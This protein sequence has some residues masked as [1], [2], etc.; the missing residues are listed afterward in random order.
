MGRSNIAALDLTTGLPTSWN[1]NADDTVN[2]IAVNGTT[3][4]AGGGF[5]SI[6]GPRPSTHIAALDATTGNTLAWFPPVSALYEFT[7]YN[8]IYVIALAISGT[9]VYAGGYFSTVGQGIG[10]P[11][12]AQFD[13]SYPVA[14]NLPVPPSSRANNVGLQI[15]GLNLHSGA[16][17]KFAYTLLKSGRVTL[18]LYNYIG[19]LQFELVNRHE[20]A[21]CHTQ[22]LNKGRL[23]AG[24]YLV[25][26]K[27]GDYHQ[28]KMI[29]LMR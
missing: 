18:R 19:Q 24:A 29:F 22:S 26:F 11:F 1:P 17:V 8:D 4:Y 7:R 20:D 6:G 2:A 28:E 5:S 21:G 9:T 16:S 10:H 13:T 27:S 12:F 23:A 3:I 15:S 25:A 14:V